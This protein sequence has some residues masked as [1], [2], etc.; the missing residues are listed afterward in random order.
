MAAAHE[1]KERVVIY[2]WHKDSSKQSQ[3]LVDMMILNAALYC[4]CE[5][6]WLPDKPLRACCSPDS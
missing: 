5:T 6:G 4:A 3:Q 1:V 2:F